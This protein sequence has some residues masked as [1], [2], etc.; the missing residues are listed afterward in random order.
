MLSVLHLLGL[1]RIEG[2]YLYFTWQM[3]G[4]EKNGNIVRVE[5][6]LEIQVHVMQLKKN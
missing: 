6:S 1:V 2:L 3:M 4:C 5:D